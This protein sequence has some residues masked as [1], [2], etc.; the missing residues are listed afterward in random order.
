MT[1]SAAVQSI[2]GQKPQSEPISGVDVVGLSRQ[3]VL[4]LCDNWD[5]TNG[6]LRRFDLEESGWKLA[7]P[8]TRVSLGRNG[9]AWG[10]GVPVRLHPDR[11][12]E[13]G[14][15]QAELIA[16]PLARRLHLKQRAYLLMHTKS[17]PA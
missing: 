10:R 5:S 11:Q 4:V 9:L 8:P 2:S 16:R 1:I 13:R 14:Y 12:R 3:I 7:A 6:W 15:N 17:R